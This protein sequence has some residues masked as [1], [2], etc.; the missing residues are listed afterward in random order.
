MLEPVVVGA[1]VV[2]AAEQDRVGQVGLA[3]TTPR[4]QV[5]R[6]RPGSRHVT[7]LGPTTLVAYGERSALGRGEQPLRPA[8]VEDLGLRTQHDG[9]EVGGAG[10]AACVPGR[11]AAIGAGGRD[12]EARSD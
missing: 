9:H 5:M 12:A 4:V 2:M 1:V 11:D 10:E 3:A 6:L 8:D 7:A